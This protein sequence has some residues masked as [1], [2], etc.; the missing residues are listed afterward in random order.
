MPPLDWPQ[1]KASGGRAEER[2]AILRPS[3]FVQ[4][5]KSHKTS[6]DKRGKNSRQQD[7]STASAVQVAQ[8][9][10]HMPTGLAN[11]RLDSGHRQ[12]GEG[13]SNKR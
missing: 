3:D 11:H 12:R 4:E 10:R 2:I 9:I 13:N 5:K 7:R 1:R 8:G 6:I